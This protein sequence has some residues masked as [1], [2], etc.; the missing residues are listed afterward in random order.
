[1]EI[2]LRPH[3]L[4]PQSLPPLI[5]ADRGPLAIVRKIVVHDPIPHAA[6]NEIILAFSGM[7]LRQRHPIYNPP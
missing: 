4:V 6:G 2:D 5:V 7:R 3:L 1:M